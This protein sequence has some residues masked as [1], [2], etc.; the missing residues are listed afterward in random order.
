MTNKIIIKEIEHK[1][2]EIFIKK[3]CSSINEQRDSQSDKHFYC[4]AMFPYPSGSLHMGHVRNYILG[5]V[6]ARHKKLQ[7]YQVFLF[8]LHAYALRLL[9]FS[10]FYIPWDGI[11]LVFLLKMLP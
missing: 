5:D 10:R 1:W 7:G 6:I 4:L 2:K 11:H 9:L 3:S 8:S